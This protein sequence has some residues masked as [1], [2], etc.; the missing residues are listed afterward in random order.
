MDDQK[1][2]EW[3][4]VF[5]FSEKIMQDGTQKRLCFVERASINHRYQ[6]L[7]NPV[8]IYRECGSDYLLQM[9]Q[10]EEGFLDLVEEACC[11]IEIKNIYQKDLDTPILTKETFEGFFPAIFAMKEAL[12]YYHFKATLLDKYIKSAQGNITRKATFRDKFNIHEKLQ[13]NLIQ[14]IKTRDERE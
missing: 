13:N 9:Q 4:K 12:T 8:Y 2:C 6:S 14:V 7:K 3:K 5:T 11:L 1:Q 10:T